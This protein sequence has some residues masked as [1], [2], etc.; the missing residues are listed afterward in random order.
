MVRMEEDEAEPHVNDQE[1]G[2]P[3]MQK[4]ITH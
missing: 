1:L 3:K 4:E 2:I